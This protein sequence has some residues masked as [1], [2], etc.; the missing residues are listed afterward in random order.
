MKKP[1]NSFGEDECG[2]FEKVE[3]EWNDVAATFVQETGRKENEKG[4]GERVI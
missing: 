1:S 2:R 4:E 3:K